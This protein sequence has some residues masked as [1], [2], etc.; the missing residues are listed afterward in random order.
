[1]QTVKTKFRLCRTCSSG[2]WCQN[3]VVSIYTSFAAGWV[4]NVGLQGFLCNTIKMKASN[5]NKKK[6]KTKKTINGLIQ[7]IRM[8]KFIGQKGLNPNYRSFVKQWRAKN[9]FNFIIADS[10]FLKLCIPLSVTHT[11]SGKEIQIFYYY[12]KICQI[13]YMLKTVSNL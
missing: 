5:N 3:N 11:N 1:M 8:D 12:L 6:K 2:I 7:M 10:I 4:K 9:R 13:N